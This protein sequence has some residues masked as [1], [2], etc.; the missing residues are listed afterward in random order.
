[1]RHFILSGDN[2]EVRYDETTSMREALRE[3]GVPESATTL[4]YAGFRT[5]DSFARAKQ[6]F[7]TSQLTIV[8]DDFH[9]ARSVML[10]RYFGI[11]AVLFIEAGPVEMVDEDTCAR[12]RRTLSSLAGCVRV[13]YAAALPRRA[14]AI[15]VA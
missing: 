11:D 8:T 9:A 13:E 14:R 7:G 5:L 12:D 15:A 3:L 1:M 4:D 2:S 6:V 10:A